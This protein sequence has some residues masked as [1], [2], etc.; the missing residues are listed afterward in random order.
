MSSPFSRRQLFKGAAA[1]AGVAVGSR[2]AAGRGGNWLLG[3]ARAQSLTT[4]PVLLNLYTFGG[5]PNIFG[6]AQ[7][8]LNNYFGVTASNTTQVNSK[9]LLDAAF[10]KCIPTAFHPNVGV[11]GYSTGSTSHTNSPIITYSFN[12]TQAVIALADAMGGS[13]ALKC[14]T[15]GGSKIPGNNQAVGSTSN[16]MVTDLGALLA[17]LGGVTDPTIPDR[18]I[19]ASGMTTAQAISSGALSANPGGLSSLQQ[20]FVSGIN[21]LQQP[22][23][24]FNYATVAQAYGVAATQTAV[25]NFAMQLIGAEVAIAA[26]A[27]VVNIV[28]KGVS[29]GSMDDHGDNQMTSPRNAFTSA[30]AGPL[31]TFLARNL[32]RTDIQLVM[33]WQGDFWRTDTGTNHANCIGVPVIGN[34]VVAGNFA[35]VSASGPNLTG[36]PPPMALWSTLAGILKV[37]AAANPFSAPTYPALVG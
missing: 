29:F 16:Q 6:N 27:N 20:A 8:W 13:A 15:L 2:L 17:A 30:M 14:V 32:G 37:P 34:N 10:A 1:V 7:P 24:V 28:P 26:G 22:V 9:V 12:N 23:P 21:A 5:F 36:A 11:V 35:Q 3:E 4:R 19:A 25:S 31:T 33:T 18:A